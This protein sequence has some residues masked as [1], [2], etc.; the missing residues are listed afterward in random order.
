MLVCRNDSI[1]S[2]IERLPLS[3]NGEFVKCIPFEKLT[4]ELIVYWLSIVEFIQKTDTNED[5]EDQLQYAICELTVFCDYLTK[6]I[7]YIKEIKDLATDS[8]T[9]EWLELESQYKLQLLIEILLTFD[10]GDEIGRQNLNAFVSKVL[11]TQILGASCVEKLVKC[12]ENIIPDSDARLQYFVDI[13]RGVIDPSSAVDI[14]EPSITMLLE[15]IRDPD[16]R[17][18]VSELK[19]RI[20]ELREA[21]S[22]STNAKDYVNL[23]KV[24]E[25]LNGC[26][27]EFLTILNTYTGDA[28][29]ASSTTMT[30]LNSTVLTS[31]NVKKVSKEWILHALEICFFA[32]CSRR[33]S[34]LTP[35]IK[36]L[37]EDFVRR[38]MKSAHM[39]IRDRA[40]KCGIA[41]S[42]LYEQLA[43]D[44]HG[45][46]YQQFV[47]HHQP[48]L[49]T[50]A[51]TGIS[52]M[53]DKYG[54]NYFE[55][56]TD[57]EKPDDSK[58]KKTRQL[59]NMSSE[60]DEQE[61]PERDTTGTDV[62]YLFAHL[63]DTC[64]E[65]S[66][67]MALATG[68]CRLILGG[69][70]ET[71][72]VISK[73]I[74]KFFNPTTCTEINQI[75]SV[76]FETLIARG[77]QECLEKA[78]LQTVF[79]ILD[80]PNESPLREIK[81]DSVIKFIVNST[82]PNANSSDRDIHNKI[83]LSFLKTMQ[84]HTTNKEL[85][86]LLSKELQT[87]EITENP[88]MRDEL[89]EEA[90]ELLRK[91]I[92]DSKIE[93]YIKSFTE[94]LSGKIVKRTQT[95]ADGEDVGSDAESVEENAMP[96]IHDESVQTGVIDSTMIDRTDDNLENN[97]N[98]ENEDMARFTTSENIDPRNNNLTNSIR[99][100]NDSVADESCV[101]SAGRTAERKATGNANKANT[102]KSARKPKQNKNVPDEN[103]NCRVCSQ[104]KSVPKHF[105]NSNRNS[106][107]LTNFIIIL[108][109]NQNRW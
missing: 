23:E 24:T 79:T 64:K 101:S 62:M 49:W 8:E 109:F 88:A 82:M 77:K 54:I 80:A 11:S 93:G 42:L 13:I 56:E 53:Y 15:N 12:V 89:K 48:R 103:E 46:L 85:L 35:N 92:N 108:F 97:E 36:Q 76:F 87:L 71:S 45:E 50:T 99:S 29:L 6:Y 59:Y 3:T 83:A 38:H 47:R 106:I 90:A 65:A 66:I 17:I 34:S 26:N 100:Q 81:A 43:K 5:E 21:E 107:H 27:E 19:L 22:D 51:V 31:L 20:M 94:I 61:E 39:E 86:K 98:R 25:K 18:K 105:Q 32:V 73:I 75:L 60:S 1:D 78:L 28:T 40:L 14:S 91:S 70:Y 37:Y 96:A 33:T 9:A 2:L 16:T 7:G 95:S 55:A 41:F 84:E 52:E 10:L 67:S 30:E 4:V 69:H 57:S 58:P 74:L 72:E 102:P 104:S 68:F 44:V 63:F